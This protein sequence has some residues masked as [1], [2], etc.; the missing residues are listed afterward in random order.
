[1]KKNNKKFI[2]IYS[3]CL[4]SK[5]IFYDFIEKNYKNIK[6]I[7][8]IPN[9]PNSKKLYKKILNSSFY[10]I[11]FQFLNVFLYNFLAPTFKTIKKLSISKKIKFF[12]LK[13]K[14]SYRKMNIIKDFNSNDIIIY[15]TMHIIEEEFLKKKNIILNFHEAPLP[16]FKGSALYFHLK[17]LKVKYFNTCIIQPNRFL[18]EGTIMF[19]SE[20]VNICNYSVFGL[21][22]KGYYLQRKLINKLID[23]SALKKNYKKKKSKYKVFSIPKTRDLNNVNI[24][25]NFKDIIRIILSY[26]K[27]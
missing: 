22:L 11:F 7:I 25:F 9:S 21:A 5:I 1:L 19:K 3:E 24:Y 10:Y 6:G 17:N 26:Y 2:I 27:I 4:R 20:S 15:S 18:D 12:E 23:N 8:K 16:R 13:K 14:P